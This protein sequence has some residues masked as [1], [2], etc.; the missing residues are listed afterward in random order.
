MLQ[1][2]EENCWLIKKGEGNMWKKSVG[3]LVLLSAVLVWCLVAEAADREL[4]YEPV[5]QLDALSGDPVSGDLVPI[6]DASAGKVKSISASLFLTGHASGATLLEFAASHITSAQLAFGL[7]QKTMT[8]GS[9][10][11]NEI[12]DGTRGKQ[13]TLQLATKGGG[14]NWI[15]GDDT[16]GNITKTGWT[17]ITFDTALDSI[18]LLWVDDSNGWIIIGNSGCTVA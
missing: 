11:T 2:V 5:S 13:V 12:S 17:T 16:S 18:T 9:N 15:I 7:V 3:L 6:L 4:Q 8:G 1:W 10:L 14:G